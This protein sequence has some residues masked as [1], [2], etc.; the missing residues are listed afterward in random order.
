MGQR[1][2][3]H[4]ERPSA[5]R[6][7]SQVRPHPEADRRTDGGPGTGSEHLVRCLL[8]HHPAARDRSWPRPDLDPGWTNAPRSLRQPLLR[9]RRDQGRLPRRRPGHVPDRPGGVPRRDARTD[10]CQ[11]R[12]WLVPLSALRP[13][14]GTR[15]LDPHPVQLPGRPGSHLAERGRSLHLQ[16]RERAPGPQG[17]GPPHAHAR[18]SRRPRHGRGIPGHVQAGSRRPR[19]T[20]R[21]PGQDPGGHL[22]QVAHPGLDL[23]RVALG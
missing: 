13:G 8:P 2:R 23:R 15:H 18:G 5:Q 21:Q 3:R 16:P 20:A 17:T 4:Q 11:Q 19:S 1:E 22:P 7:A 12:G 14:L 10:R 9:H 6:H